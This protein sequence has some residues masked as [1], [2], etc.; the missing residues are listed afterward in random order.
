MPRRNTSKM[1]TKAFNELVEEVGWN[2]VEA[3][4]ADLGISRRQ[5]F[6]HTQGEQVA[7][8]TT[9]AR[10]LEMYATHGVP[11]RWRKA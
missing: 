4:A 1:T 5:G 2:S 11:K 3:A 7:I 8:P 9:V 6:R 10:L